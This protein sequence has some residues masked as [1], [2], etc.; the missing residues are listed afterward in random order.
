MP[1]KGENI[2]KRKDGRWEG[3]Y[4]KDRK[5][6]GKAVYGYIYAR[7]Y[8][9][10]KYRLREAEQVCCRYSSENCNISKSK[11]RFSEIAVNWL[12]QKKPQFKEST[13]TKYQNLLQCYI[14]PNL[15]EISLS[16]LTVNI[17][18]NFC[19]QMLQTGG[20]R[21]KGL[22]PKTVAD[23]LSL[24]RSIL[25]N[26]SYNGYLIPFDLKSVVVRQNQKEMRILTKTEQQIL[27]QFIINNP[28]PKNIGILICMFTGIRVGEV[29][30]LQCED[31]SIF[32]K[33]IHIHQTMQR[34]QT[35]NNSGEKTKIIVTTPKSQC[36]IR[37][38]PIPDELIDLIKNSNMSVSGYFLTGSSKKWI[39]P[40]TMQN[41]FKSISRKCNI[42][43]VNFHALRHT[44]ATRCI[45]YGFDIKSLSEILGHANVNITMNRYVHPT[46]DLK[47]NN[48]ERLSPLLAVI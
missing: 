12:E 8:H 43:E 48:M 45:E 15:G 47:R 37:S 21:Q 23:I 1:R 31:I 14:L 28:T 39:E 9:D 7:T 44:F 27:C 3:R 34:I 30:A 24:M 46:M 41:H 26:A 10:V 42:K 22:S 17:I 18:D 33:T 35:N 19:K 11:E 5:A 25:R 6:S 2:Y 13:Y 32:E 36:S 29:C 40:R 20:N 38:I 4:I 16:Q